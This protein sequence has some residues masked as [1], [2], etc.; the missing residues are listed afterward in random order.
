[1]FIYYALSEYFIQCVKAASN[2]HNI[3]SAYRTVY[4]AMPDMI[5]WFQQLQ[6]IA[7]KY[8]GKLIFKDTTS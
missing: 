4:L 6:I 8:R 5:V 2:P 7:G 1:M 3:P